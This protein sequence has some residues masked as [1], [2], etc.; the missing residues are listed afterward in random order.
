M[1]SIDGKRTRAFP[2]Q[3]TAAVKAQKHEMHKRF[4][5]CKVVWLAKGKDSHRV[6]GD[7]VG[8]IVKRTDHDRTYNKCQNFNLKTL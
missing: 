2:V 7:A 6:G 3:G 1:K 8:K 4:W 5:Q